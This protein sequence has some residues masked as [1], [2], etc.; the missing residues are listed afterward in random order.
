[1]HTKIKPILNNVYKRSVNERVNVLWLRHNYVYILYIIKD[2][3][4]FNAA[5]KH[6]YKISFRCLTL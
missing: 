4:T 3:M 5:T 2:Y 6:S 1:M